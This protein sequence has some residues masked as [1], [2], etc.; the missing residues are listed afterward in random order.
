MLA[1]S[2]IK[3]FFFSKINNTKKILKH[4]CYHCLVVMNVTL[5]TKSSFFS[6]LNRV[7]RAD[8]SQTREKRIYTKNL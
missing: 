3:I 2:S 8:Y 6:P 5:E 7:G 4:N 1:I